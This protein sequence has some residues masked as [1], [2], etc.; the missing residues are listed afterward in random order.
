[1]KLANVIMPSLMIILAMG[2]MLIPTNR[3]AAQAARYAFDITTNAPARSFVDNNW[4]LRIH[5]TGSTYTY[6]IKNFQTQK[7]FELKKGR[8]IQTNGKHYYK[9]N[10][11]GTLYQVIWNPND[12][13][14]ARVQAFEQG[15][16]IFNQL[17]KED[18]SGI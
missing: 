5:R 9:W 6:S 1:M 11:K 8:L 3:Q 14:Y 18:D 10:N 13:D 7:Y 2:S 4:G 12:P 15:K 17:L 16:Q